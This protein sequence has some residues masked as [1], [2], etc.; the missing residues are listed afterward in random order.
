[1]KK[2]ILNGRMSGKAT[3]MK[4]RSDLLDIIFNSRLFICYADGI[5]HRYG[6]S[7]EIVKDLNNKM[8]E[9]ADTLL[10]E[11]FKKDK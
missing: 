3:K 7:E 1:M 5:M 11:G 8:E 9:L 6:A 10:K 4:N 2:V